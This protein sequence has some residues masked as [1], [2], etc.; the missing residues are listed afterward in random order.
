MCGCGG[1]GNKRGL[2]PAVNLRLIIEVNS[3]WSG[4]G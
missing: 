2:C 1:D 4:A 3:G